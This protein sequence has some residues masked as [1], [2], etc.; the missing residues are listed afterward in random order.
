MDVTPPD[1]I[2]SV[3]LPDD[4]KT[5]PNYINKAMEFLRFGSSREFY[6][7]FSWKLKILVKSVIYTNDKIK[8]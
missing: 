6:N 5:F 8:E 1:L 3:F 7:T 2:D 4:L